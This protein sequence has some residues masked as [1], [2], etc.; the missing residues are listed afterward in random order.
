VSVKTQAAGVTEDRPRGWRMRID[1][2]TIGDTAEVS[3]VEFVP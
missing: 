2:Q 3:N 1:I